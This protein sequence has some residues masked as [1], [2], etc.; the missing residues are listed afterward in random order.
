MSCVSERLMCTGNATIDKAGCICNEDLNEPGYNISCVNGTN[1]ITAPALYFDLEV[2]E[3]SSGLDPDNIG[4]PLWRLSLCLL[5]SWIIV[6]ACLY[7][8]V[9]SSGKVVYFTATFPY[10]ILLILLVRGCTMPGAMK[11]IKKFIIPDWDKFS[12]LSL[13]VD[14]AGQMFF[15]LSVCFGGIMMFGSYNKFHNN[16]YLDSL[17]ISVM[18]LVTSIIAG[19]VIFS[20]LGGLS[21]ESNVEIENLAKGGFELAFVVYPEALARLPIPQLWSILFFFM[22]FILG[23]D[24]E[25]GLLETVLT[26]IQDE[27]PKLRDY[28]GFICLG[29]GACCFFFALPCVCPVS[30]IF[31]F[32][33]FY[34]KDYHFLDSY[35]TKFQC[36]ASKKEN[37]TFYRHR[38]SKHNFINMYF[39]FQMLFIYRMIRYKPPTYDNGEVYPEFAQIIGWVLSALCLCPIPLYCV[40]RFIVE[41][42]NTEKPTC[43]N[44][45]I[46]RIK[47]TIHRLTTP[48]NSWC[49]AGSKKK[50]KAETGKGKYNPSFEINENQ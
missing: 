6:V 36:V 47:E 10:I 41:F 17:I 24:S 26:C 25:F 9:K 13:W 37:I 39:S 34:S 49:P 35:K 42:L 3:K 8:G 5:L 44:A 48:T 33:L 7:K 2:T 12:D 23:L 40:Y 32:L 27:Y 28:K 18:D 1:F 15:S 38:R 22:L 31:V 20:V 46:V 29:C 21:T 45:N 14:A 43:K 11:G 50:K 4:I 16:I 19:F 30:C